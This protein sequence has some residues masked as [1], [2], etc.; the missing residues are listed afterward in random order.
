[1]KNIF[2]ATTFVLLVNCTHKWGNFKSYEL[3]APTNLET[4]GEPVTGNDCS[5]VSN[6]WFRNNVADAIRDA[7]AKAPAGTTGLKDV[8]VSAVNFRY[9]FTSCINVEGIPVKESTAAPAKTKK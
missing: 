2:I 7:I 3:Q 8:T 4:L 5:F 6:Q 1:M 9:L